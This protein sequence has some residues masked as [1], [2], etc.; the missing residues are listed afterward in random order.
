MKPEITIGTCWDGRTYY[1]IEYI[2]ILY[3]AVRRHTTIPHDFVLYIGP[4]AVGKTDSL[5]TGIRVVP[6]KMTSWWLV[7]K[8]W[9]PNPV[10]IETDSLLY[11][12][13]DIVIL[14]SLDDLI[15]FPSDHACSRE[16]PLEHTATGEEIKAMRRENANIGIS[17]I[18]HNAGARV[19]EEY[20][21]AGSPQWDPLTVRARGE[22]PLAG[23]TIINNPKYGVTVDL[24]PDN[25][26]CSYKYQVLKRGIPDDCRIVHFHGLPKPADC[27]REPFVRDH[28]R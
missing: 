18:R 13:L 7:T 25:W 16:Y 3:W 22:L 15:N 11:L 21:K 23:Q 1:P 24:F 5:D 12:D 6:T 28:W 19:W 17:L 27:M 14:G 8:F 10:G 9:E 20:V 2:N 4:E 26:V